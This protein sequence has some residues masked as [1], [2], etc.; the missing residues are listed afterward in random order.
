MSRKSSCCSV[1]SKHFRR[2]SFSTRIEYKM[3]CYRIKSKKSKSISV[4]IMMELYSSCFSVWICRSSSS[5][6]KSQNRIVY[7]Y[8]LRNKCSRTSLYSNSSSDV[9]ASS[10]INISA[11]RSHC[12]GNSVHS[13]SHTRGRIK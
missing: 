5:I 11:F 13:N 4:F 6:S 2:S 8:I 10:N 3:F 12:N 7:S 1:W 9:Y